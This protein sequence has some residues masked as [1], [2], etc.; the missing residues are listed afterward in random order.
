MGY[1]LDLLDETS[2]KNQQDVVRN[3][4]RQR[5]D[6]VPYGKDRFALAEALYPEGHPYRYMTIGRHED[7]EAASVDDVKGFFR[8]WYVPSNATLT[9]A[10]DFELADAKA[11]VTK[12]FGSYPKLAKPQHKPVAMPEL[13]ATVRKEVDDGFARLTRIHYAWH[14]PPLFTDAD[15]ELDVVAT[16][17]GAVPVPTITGIRTDPESAASIV[18]YAQVTLP[19]VGVSAMQLPDRLAMSAVTPAGGE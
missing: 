12:W 18:P 14:S 16:V 9:L 17:L 8:E 4:R 19:G 15:F 13:A 6:N 5:Y 10:G 7:L 2:L 3:E 11:L 1:L